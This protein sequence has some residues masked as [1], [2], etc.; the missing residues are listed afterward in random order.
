MDDAN[1]DQMA[2]LDMILDEEQHD[3]NSVAGGSVAAHGALPDPAVA[4]GES[5]SD[6]IPGDQLPIPRS[7]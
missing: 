6:L 3:S 4:A 1:Y 5:I 2:N 7:S